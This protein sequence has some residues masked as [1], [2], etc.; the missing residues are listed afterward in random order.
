VIED[1]FLVEVVHGPYRFPGSVVTVRDT[2]LRGV[3]F[4]LDGTL[5]DT[6]PATFAAFRAVFRSRLGIE[7]HDTEIRAMFGP[8]ERG[9][10]RLRIPDSAEQAHEEFLLAYER[11][12]TSEAAPFPG[13]VDL[14]DTLRDRGVACAVVTGKG[15]QSAALSLRLLGLEA[16]FPIVEAGSPDGAVKPA[17]MRRVLDAWGLP[18]ERVAGIGDAPS[19]IRAAKATG[20][21]ALGAAWAATADASALRALEPAAVFESVTQARSWLATRL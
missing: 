7:F 8:D 3:I 10:F 12:Q 15:A 11:E 9:V 6:L 1:V 14:L 20:M 16:Y 19:D 5:G 2:G 4:D 13:I 18:P 21:I 17:A